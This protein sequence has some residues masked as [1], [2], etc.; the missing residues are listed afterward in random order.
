MQQLSKKQREVQAAE[1]PPADAESAGVA[2]GSPPPDDL[3]VAEEEADELPFL[4]VEEPEL[5]PGDDAYF[6]EL[7]AKRWRKPGHGDRPE[8]P[9]V[10]HRHHGSGS[11]PFILLGGIPDD[12][13]CEVLKNHNVQ[14]VVTCFKQP[15]TSK[16]AKFPSGCL[17]R[18]F[19]VSDERIHNQQWTQLKPLV[20]RT[21]EHGGSIC[22]HCMAG[23]H[24]APVGDRDDP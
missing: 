8:P 12:A 6:D 5:D 16:G 23:V 24:R 10:V 19:A 13:A 2:V 7:A 4:P 18:Q 14:L 15:A 1:N 3:E 21:L 20:R 11:G 9:A 17:I 22:V